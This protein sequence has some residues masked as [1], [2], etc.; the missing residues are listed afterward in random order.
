MYGEE[1][2]TYALSVNADIDFAMGFFDFILEVNAP[3]DAEYNIGGTAAIIEKLYRKYEF[4]CILIPA[5]YTGRMLAPRTAAKL[6]TGL[7]AD[8]T[9]I[10]HEDGFVMMIRPA[11]CGKLMAGIINTDTKPLMMSVRGGVFSYE[12]CKDKPTKIIETGEVLSEAHI[13]RISHEIKPQ[14]RDIRDADV[15]VSAGGGAME[16][17][18]LA[19]QLAKRLK[20]M[21]SA[22]RRVVDAGIADRSIQVGQSGK[23][24]H[25]RLYIAAG[26]YGSIQ[27]I[28][29]LKR[30]E[31]IIAINTDVNAPICSLSDIVVEGDAV[32]FM[33]M[34]INRIDS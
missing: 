9:A 7:T 19:E 6:R 3:C 14:S 29:G 30:V 31:H 33:E 17:L 27:H 34:L 4:D 25:P 26:I 1:I 11:F 15:L 13:K 22:S 10:G 20:G 12:G 28:A 5:T 23:V 18:P 2:C 8:V 24:V 16:S 21:T 32:K